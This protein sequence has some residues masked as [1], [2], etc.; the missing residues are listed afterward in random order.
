MKYCQVN[1][2]P[3]SVPRKD[4]KGQTAPSETHHLHLLY[5]PKKRYLFSS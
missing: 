5:R 1:D 4:L 3:A 2:G